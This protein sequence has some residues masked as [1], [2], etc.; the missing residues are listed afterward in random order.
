MK[1]LQGVRREESGGGGGGGGP[2]GD[3]RALEAEEERI[4]ALADRGHEL[5]ALG[6]VLANAPEDANEEA[7]QITPGVVNQEECLGRVALE[8]DGNAQ[9]KARDE[10]LLAELREAALRLLVRLALG[11]EQPR[12]PDRG[13]DDGRVVLRRV[14]GKERMREAEEQRTRRDGLLGYL[15]AKRRRTPAASQRTRRQMRPKPPEARLL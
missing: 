2:Q 3:P 12:L 1:S 11:G 6:G 14:R 15:A 13:G 4:E 10:V 8:L 7:V 9:E 5:E